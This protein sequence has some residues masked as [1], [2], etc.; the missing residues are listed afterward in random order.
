[1]ANEYGAATQAK[2]K[3]EQ[4]KEHSVRRMAKSG[5]GVKSSSSSSASSSSTIDHAYW[6]IAEFYQLLFTAETPEDLIPMLS[7]A[8]KCGK[9]TTLGDD[10]GL[11][12]YKFEVSFQG[13]P[14]QTNLVETPEKNKLL[15]TNGEGTVTFWIED[16]G[17]SLK[18]VGQV[19]GLD[20]YITK[21]L[22]HR[23][24]KERYEDCISTM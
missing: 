11:G 14:V 9:T 21:N 10:P 16:G 18:V 3:P 1:M 17:D 4:H 5:K 19:G 6:E 20:G 24:S 15:G 8:D 7:E 13:T 22:W 12:Y 23:I 2:G